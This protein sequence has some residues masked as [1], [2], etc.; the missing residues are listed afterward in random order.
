M[1]V[2]HRHTPHRHTPLR[3]EQHECRH[4]DERRHS[5]ENRP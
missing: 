4:G 2:T 3:S 5:K 1:T